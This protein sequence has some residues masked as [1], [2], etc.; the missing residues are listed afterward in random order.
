MAGLVFFGIYT[1][2]TYKNF[3]E[4]KYELEFNL[5]EPVF[6]NDLAH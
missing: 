3:I 4:I 6:L 5:P 2:K 1:K